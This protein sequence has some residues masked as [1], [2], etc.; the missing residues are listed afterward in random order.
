MSGEKKWHYCPVCK[1]HIPTRVLNGV[2]VFKTHRPHSG[3]QRGAFCSGS[4]QPV[5]RWD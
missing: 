1:R 4:N 5:G 3:M 2:R